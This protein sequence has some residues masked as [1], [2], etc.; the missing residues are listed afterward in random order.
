M[1]QYKSKTESEFEDL[2]SD[3]FG[4]GEA[5]EP[6]KAEER[7]EVRLVDTLSEEKRRK[8]LQLSE[9]IDPKN[10]QSITLYGTQAQ[11]KLLNFSHHMLEH[12]QKRCRRNRK[13]FKRS[14]EKAGTGES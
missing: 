6:G 3:P 4:Q 2:L 5:M 10:H 12:V 1:S 7:H 11:S 8:A 9:Q 13:D 14:H